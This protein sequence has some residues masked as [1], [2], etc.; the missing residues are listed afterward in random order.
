[1]SD[2]TRRIAILVA[3]FNSMITEQLLM[4][5]EERLE[6]SGVDQGD[7]DVL[8]VPGAWELPQAAQAIVR[9][10]RHRAILALGCVIRGETSHFDYVAGQASDGLGHVALQADIPVLF[11]VLTTEN[12]EQALDRADTQGSNKG[13]EVAEALLEM[14]ELFDS[15][16]DHE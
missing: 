16:T 14:V 15:L 12:A 4:G 9:A 8:Y 2:A 3:R 7:V 5:A 11:G 13:G 6:A 10:G 1:M